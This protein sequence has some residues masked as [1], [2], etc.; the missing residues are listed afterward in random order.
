MKIYRVCF[1]LFFLV[2]FSCLPGQVISISGSGRGYQNAELRIYS[3]SDPI[4]K[5][6]KPLFRTLCDEKGSFSFEVPCKG[7]E[8]IYIRTGIFCF[9]I[10]AAEGSKYEIRLPDFISKPRGEEQNPLFVEKNLIP[11]IV[12]DT[13]DINNLI[14]IFDAEYDPIFND[15]AERVFRNIKKGEIPGLIEKLN[16]VSRANG[17]VFYSNFV[18]YRMMM[19]NQV[20][21]GTYPGRIEDSTLINARFDSE[22]QAFLDLVEQ[23]FTGYFRGL[24]SGPLREAYNRALTS[25]SLNDLKYVILK[26]GKAVEKQLQEY[27]ILLNLCSEYYNG[28]VPLENTI[29]IISSLKSDGFSPFI[30]EIASQLLEKIVSTLPGTIPPDFSLLNDNGR[31]VSL[32]DF[33]GRYLIMSFTRSDNPA[34]VMEF[35]LLNMWYKKY[36]ADLEVI[37]ILT[38]HDYKSAMKK[39]ENNGFKWTFLDGS[40]S[41]FLEYQY[42]IKMYPTFL[43]LDRENRIIAD[44]A[45]FPSEYLESW[46]RKLIREEKERSDPKD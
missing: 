32:K 33:K 46:I 10:N 7:R 44:P 26:D 45:S 1:T 2:I 15:V 29:K 18:K 35:G 23:L 22:N 5:R 17:P 34:T 41:D 21:F 28:S 37:T 13:N 31:K 30:K 19:L 27:I 4:T 12:N 9:S 39:M 3:Q 24:A 25:S 43:V 40:S 14:R 8:L 38:D 20:A 42:D 11:E 16:R 36:Q 6:F